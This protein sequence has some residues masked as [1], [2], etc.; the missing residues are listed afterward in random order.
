[1]NLPRD[2]LTGFR[3]KIVQPVVGASKGF[4]VETPDT[5]FSLPHAIY[6]PPHYEY[7][8]YPSSHYNFLCMET[9]DGIYPCSSIYSPPRWYAE[10]RQCYF[11]YGTSNCQLSGYLSRITSYSHFVDV[12]RALDL[13]SVHEALL[14][15]KTG[16]HLYVLIR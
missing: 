12:G 4:I 6:I 8:F 7:T 14:T 9:L 2:S 16:C 5:E 11:R 1:M 10:M 13:G 3:S 15:D